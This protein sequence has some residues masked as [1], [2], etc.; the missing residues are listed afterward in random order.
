MQTESLW[1]DRKRTIFGLPWSFTK[2]RLTEDKFFLQTGFFNTKE[3]EVRLYRILDV[4]LNR[5]F[6]EKLFGLGT[7]TVCSADKSLGD[8][9]IRRIKNPK[10]VRDLMSDVVEQQRNAKGIIGREFLEGTHLEAGI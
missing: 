7:L 3:D 8:F 10:K 1:R 5:S 4:S 2:Y 9:L 6:R